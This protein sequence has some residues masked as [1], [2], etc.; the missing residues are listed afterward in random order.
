MYFCIT[1]GHISHQ[2]THFFSGISFLIHKISLVSKN[3]FNDALYTELKSKNL[4]YFCLIFFLVNKLQCFVL[5]NF[6]SFKAW[7]DCA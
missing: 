3:I 4:C 7:P 1:H 2:Q 5:M 6:S